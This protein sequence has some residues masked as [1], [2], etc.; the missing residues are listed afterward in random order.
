MEKRVISIG[1]DSFYI[2]TKA[3]CNVNEKEKMNLYEMDKNGSKE[4]DLQ[5]NDCGWL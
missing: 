2:C 3:L 5:G 1:Y 4:K